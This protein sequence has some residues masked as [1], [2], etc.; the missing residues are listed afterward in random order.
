MFQ[1]KTCLHSD[2]VRV[3][4]EQNMLA[5]SKPKLCKAGKIESL[6]STRHQQSSSNTQRTLWR[7]PQTRPLKGIHRAHS[8]GWQTQ[9]ELGE[10]KKD[11]PSIS[12]VSR[13]YPSYALLALT[14]HLCCEGQLLP[15]CLLALDPRSGGFLVCVLGE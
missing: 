9:K 12:T 15:A 4:S 6:R 14:P 8:P 13:A 3:G 2:L 5:K 7:N 11:N 10:R 1:D